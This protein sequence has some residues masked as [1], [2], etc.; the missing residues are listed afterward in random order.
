MHKQR[1][2]CLKKGHYCIRSIWWYKF[3]PRRGKNLSS[4]QIPPKFKGA[5]N[6]V[7]NK[8]ES[9]LPTYP[10]KGR[11]TWHNNEVPKIWF[12]CQTCHL[13]DFF[14]L[15]Y[16]FEDNCI[17]HDDDVNKI[18][19]KVLVL[20]YFQIILCKNLEI[21]LILATQLLFGT[22]WPRIGEKDFCVTEKLHHHMIGADSY[23]DA[24]CCPE[25][26]CSDKIV[27]QAS[28]VHPS[29]YSSAEALSLEWD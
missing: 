8:K 3:A 21:S 28:N 19:L 24:S 22:T 26:L 14:L 12:F 2:W 7:A 27:V 13:F 9:I 15:L 29:L 6:N 11:S 17:F 16:I 18:Q 5:L 20:K 23:N 1:A 10:A 25:P 4:K